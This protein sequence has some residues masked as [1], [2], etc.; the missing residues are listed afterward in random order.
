M[1]GLMMLGLLILGGAACAEDDQQEEAAQES[2]C[3]DPKGFEGFIPTHVK[4][5][6]LR[7]EGVRCWYNDVCG[8][9]DMGG[10]EVWYW[11]AGE[12]C[13]WSFEVASLVP[14]DQARADCVEVGGELDQQTDT[15]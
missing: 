6:D 9:C 10:V 13:V 1:R 14:D 5:C 11:R 4:D 3:A 2:E 8:V 12:L 7:A 15:D